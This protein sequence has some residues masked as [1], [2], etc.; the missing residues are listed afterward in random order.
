MR[1][2]LISSGSYCVIISVYLHVYVVSDS[3]KSIS[4]ERHSPEREISRH[5]T[6]ICKVVRMIRT[7]TCLRLFAPIPNLFIHSTD[8]YSLLC[9]K[10]FQF[11]IL[12]SFC[13]MTVLW[14]DRTGKLFL[15]LS[16]G[17]EIFLCLSSSPPANCNVISE[18]PLFSVPMC[19]LSWALQSA[20][21]KAY[22]GDWG[23]V[24]S[25]RQACSRTICQHITSMRPD[26][27][28]IFWSRVNGARKFGFFIILLSTLSAWLTFFR[29]EL[30][31]VE[32]VSFCC[33]NE[34]ASYTYTTW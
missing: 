9:A 1:Y 22:H 31:M 19:Y 28:R 12:I 11:L 2:W 8:L 3:D 24:W 23:V 16:G 13:L 32:W 15:P 4:W 7:Y 29:K 27:T 18:H 14:N 20:V 17:G 30:Q 10:E 5:T 34:L 26:F 21:L 25:C 33:S 6:N